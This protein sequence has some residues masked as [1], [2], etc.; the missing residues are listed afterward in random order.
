MVPSGRAFYK[1]SGSGNDFVMVDARLE[2]PGQL[3]EPQAIQRVCARATGVG[4]DGIVF[5]EP[6]SIAAIRLNYLNADG[7]PAD[8]C[9]NATL[10]T[11]RL[12]VELGMADPSGF[13]IET[14]SGIVRAR[15]A[16]NQPEIDLAAVTEVWADTNGIE[17]QTGERRIG[18]ALVGVPHIVILCDDVA[19]VDVVGRGRPLRHHPTMHQ[20]AN[21]NFVGPGRDGRWR[22][23]TYERGV[24]AETLACGSGS[25]ATT[26]LLAAW[27]KIEPVEGGGKPEFAADLETS[28]GRI[29]HVGLSRRAE[30]WCPTLGGEARVVFAGKL[31]EI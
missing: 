11:T 22:M 6:S 28:S 30:A 23:R 5:L 4:A 1:M 16:Q 2:P 14:P 13:D 9:G 15:F 3:A 25:V 21:V 7:S 10:C 26:I 20:G 18:F 8:L 12:A 17:V 24:E 19:T 31:G 27:G 29:L